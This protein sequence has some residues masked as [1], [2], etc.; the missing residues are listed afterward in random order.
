MFRQI[1]ILGCLL[2]LGN[3]MPINETTNAT[4]TPMMTN[5]TKS[6]TEDSLPINKQF[7]CHFDYQ[8]GP[9][10][11]KT[12]PDRQGQNRTRCVCESRYATDDYYKPC[13]YQRKSRTISF[14]ITLFLVPGFLGAHWFYLAAGN[15]GYIFAGVLQ[16][17]LV[18]GGLIMMNYKSNHH[19]K[20]NWYVGDIGGIMAML[21]LLFDLLAC[22]VIVIGGFSDGKGID[23][24]WYWP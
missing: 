18:W 7:Q 17:V 6:L 23:T 9:G 19:I 2:V 14:L 1:I 22:F 21:G 20:Y 5:A 11:C 8:C 4:I 10:K 24:I 16:I 15:G 3:S 12:K 13:D